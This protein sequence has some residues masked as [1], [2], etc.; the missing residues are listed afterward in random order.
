M[1]KR[2]SPPDVIKILCVVLFIVLSSFLLLLWRL[3]CQ[4][5]WFYVC[6]VYIVVVSV[7]HT[8]CCGN[9]PISGHVIISTTVI[10][11]MYMLHAFGVI[12]SIANK[13]TAN[14]STLRS[15]RCTWEENTSEAWNGK[16]CQCFDRSALFCFRAKR[17]DHNCQKSVAVYRFKPVFENC[18]SYMV[19]L[20]EKPHFK[21]I[22][23]TKL[24][25]AGLQAC[26]ANLVDFLFQD[27]LCE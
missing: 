22:C 23:T 8:L 7:Q 24:R 16:L 19:Q 15:L 20:D 17:P 26:A 11:C 5:I 6:D 1:Q 18:A 13:M 3:I 25:L 12:H 2:R 21:E 14:H 27:R 9:L 4:W 10:Y